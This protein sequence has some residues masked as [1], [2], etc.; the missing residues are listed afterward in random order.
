MERIREFRCRLRAE[1]DAGMGDDLNAGLQNHALP[2][3]RRADMAGASE[4][5][6]HVA[7]MP[8]ILRLIAAVRLP[9][10]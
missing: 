10:G 1:S 7:D 5:V 6:R 3:C 9:P 4:R 8:E 2:E